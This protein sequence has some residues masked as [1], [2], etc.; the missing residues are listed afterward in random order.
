[1]CVVNKICADIQP[2][3]QGIRSDRHN[4]EQDWM[5]VWE[6]EASS[7]SDGGRSGPLEPQ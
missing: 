5:K 3:R 1:M 6:T 4:H 7:G 2:N